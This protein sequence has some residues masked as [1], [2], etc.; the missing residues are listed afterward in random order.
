MNGDGAENAPS[1]LIG[2][3]TNS[4]TGCRTRHRRDPRDAPLSER[5]I[6]ALQF[7]G[8]GA[9]V[10][11]YQLHEAVF[12]RVSE[13]V[14]SRFVHRA[15]TRGLVVVSR[16]RGI[17]INRLRLT[18]RG[19]AT[20]IA[21]GVDPLEIF[22]PHNPIADGH[23]EHH[24]WI[25]DVLTVLGRAKRK[26]DILVPAWALERRFTPR[27]AAIPDVLASFAAPG[28]DSLLLAVEIDRGSESIA[29]VFAP[30]LRELC[31][32]LG[33]WAGGATSLIV[34]FTNGVRRREAIQTRV[35]KLP[36]QIVTELLPTVSGRAGLADF[37]RTLTLP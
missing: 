17:G 37:E 9:E 20:L 16:W 31:S 29:S 26:A 10:A 5:D 12:G 27:P 8:R 7:I 24:L 28:S 19:R 21:H 30:K 3:P 34:V 33:A 6:A 1:L 18:M 36:M 4:P 11:Q 25:V 2:V 35:E 15:A 23:I 14:V 32:V 13:V 22:V